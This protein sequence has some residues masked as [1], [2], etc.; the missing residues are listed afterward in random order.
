MKLLHLFTRCQTLAIIHFKWSNQELNNNWI[1]LTASLMF[2]K[3][4]TPANIHRLNNIEAAGG[5]G[6][7]TL[8]DLTQRGWWSLPA[9]SERRLVRFHTHSSHSSVKLLYWYHLSLFHFQGNVPTLCR[10]ELCYLSLH[11]TTNQRSLTLG[12]T[13]QSDSWDSLRWCSNIKNVTN[14][15]THPRPIFRCIM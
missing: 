8:G 14:P 7:W 12:F 9:G 1:T 4:S 10:K 5:R 2:L 13:N 11:V 6:G 15:Y 3:P